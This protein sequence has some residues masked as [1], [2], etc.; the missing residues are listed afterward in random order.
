[1]KLYELMGDIASMYCENGIIDTTTFIGQIKQRKDELNVPRDISYRDETF[2][3]V[4]EFL[5]DYG[6]NP[7]NIY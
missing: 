3:M 6:I 7:K 4:E 1:M 5:I 2:K